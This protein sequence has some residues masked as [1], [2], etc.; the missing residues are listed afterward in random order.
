[1]HAGY[2][3]YNG[4]IN[5]KEYHNGT[6]NLYFCRPLYFSPYFFQVKS[7]FVKLC[8]PFMFVFF[9]QQFKTNHGPYINK[10]ALL[11]FL[12]CY[13]LSYATF[14]V[15]NNILTF[16]ILCIYI[17][18]VNYFFYQNYLIN[19]LQFMDNIQF[20]VSFNGELSLQI[21]FKMFLLKFYH[22][23]NIEYIFYF[24]Y[25]VYLVFPQLQ[26]PGNL[27]YVVYYKINVYDL[28]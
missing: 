10:C 16:Q 1:M 6:V 27:Q 24:I 7:T 22:Q 13:I 8:Q 14:L 23:L 9:P 3:Y 25:F 26:I 21:L 4:L 17:S 2:D 19:S 15:I 28:I 11:Y 5:S 20:V 12:L 18:Y